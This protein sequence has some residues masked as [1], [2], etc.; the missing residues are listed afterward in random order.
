MLNSWQLKSILSITQFAAPNSAIGTQRDEY[1][2]PG[3]MKKGFD[4]Q[5]KRPPIGE[6][7]R[8]TSADLATAT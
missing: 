7:D 2:I 4:L 8:A 6:V 1:I 5:P 3:W